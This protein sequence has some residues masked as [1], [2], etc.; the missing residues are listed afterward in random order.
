M[1]EENEYDVDHLVGRDRDGATGN[2]RRPGK[3][4]GN[5]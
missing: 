4:R 1:I 3:H 5:R 2:K